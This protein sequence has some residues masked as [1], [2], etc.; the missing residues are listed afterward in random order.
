MP[1][2]DFNK[3]ALQLHRNHIRYRCSPVNLLHIFRTPFPQ[4]NSGE[5]LLITHNAIHRIR[6]LIGIKSEVT[7]FIKTYYITCLLEIL[8]LRLSFAVTI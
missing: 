8:T 3:V 2:Y 4:N 6:N 7:I 1:K 5:M